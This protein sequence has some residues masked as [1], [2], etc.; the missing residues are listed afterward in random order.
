MAIWDKIVGDDKN[1]QPQ[2]YPPVQA[3]NTEEHRQTG[4]GFNL[5]ALRD[6]IDGSDERQVE[7]QHREQRQET[8]KQETSWVDKVRSNHLCRLI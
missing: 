5:G 6:A 3:V 8:K 7:E 2:G 4:Q 1:D